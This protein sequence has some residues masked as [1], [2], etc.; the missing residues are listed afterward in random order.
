MKLTGR[1]CAG[2]TG[3]LVVFDGTLIC[4]VEWKK[5]GEM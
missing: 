2:C 5:Q 1:L 3:A 4:F